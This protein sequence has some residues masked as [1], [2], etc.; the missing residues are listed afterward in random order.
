MEETS[1]QSIDSMTIEQFFNLIKEQKGISEI[2]LRIL[3]MIQSMDK[4]LD[5]AG[6]KLFCIYFSL[7]D[8]GNI[9][10]PLEENQLFKDWKK[11]WDGLLLVS[12]SYSDEEKENQHLEFKKII[13]EGINNLLSGKIDLIQSCDEEFFTKLFIIQEIEN[14]K[15]LFATKYFNAKVSIEEQIKVLF[16]QQNFTK[17]EVIDG[18]NNIIEK[19]QKVTGETLEKEQAEAIFY[20]EHGNLVVT[21][22]PGTGKTTTICYLLW[23]LLEQSDENG[24]PYLRYD[25]RLAAPSGKAAERI[26]ESISNSLNG[27][28]QDK[29]PKNPEIYK[30]LVQT[31]PSTIHRLL[32]YNPSTNAF[33]Y[34]KTNKF[35]EKTIFV[36]DEA[37][38]IDIELFKSLLEAIPEGAKLFILGD[39]DQLPSV[40]AGGVLGEL[41]GKIGGNVIHLTKSRRFNESS[42]V[43]RLKKEVQKDA[44]FPQNMNNYG[45]WINQ[46]EDFKII[47]SVDARTALPGVEKNPVLF[48]A[49]WKEAKETKTKKKEII[50]YLANAWTNSFYNGLVKKASKIDRTKVTSAQLD[51]L[52][53]ESLTARILCAEN[54]GETGV[55]AINSVISKQICKE[56]NL[57][58]DDNGYFEGE[59]LILTE[60]Q[61]MFNLYNGDCGVVVTFKDNE[62]KYLM[63]EK[64]QVGTQET[65]ED[66]Q[67]I[68][69][70]G[71]YLFYPLYLLPLNSILPAYAITI[72]KSQGSGYKQIMVILP[73]KEGHPLLNRQIFYTAITRTEGNTYIIATKQAMNY[74]KKTLIQR[75]TNIQV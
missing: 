35:N 40:Q 74:A 50:K 5:E 43:G 11:K 8:D 56:N 23:K 20:G 53:K 3:K 57:K 45:T 26:K 4:N 1:L 71:D 28:V 47:P 72:H 22:G 63:I 61:K 17:Q 62:I 25:L 32:S 13:H 64:K 21:G 14:V 2:W 37:S 18:T 67:E 30:K 10:I 48:Y 51:E 75:Y 38:M 12:E 54:Q 39:K 55:E 49:L 65:E 33:I 41:L 73:E 24:I 59:L 7:V 42:Q 16:I 19:F 58:A 6:L 68:F 52:W 34:N 15:W 29:V 46:K 36:I 31:D 66:V 9:C 70:K 60:N 69:R 44:D 27:F